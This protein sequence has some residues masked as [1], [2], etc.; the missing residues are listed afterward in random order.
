MK[1][2]II[3]EIELPQGVSAVLD[4]P[5]LTIKGPKGEN[6]RSFDYPTISLEVKDG[7]VVVSAQKATKREKR[8]IGT[9]SSHI[10]NL[11]QGVQE[12]FVYKLKICSGHF[13]MNVSVSGNSVVVKNFLGEK[14]PRVIT[15]SNGVEIKVNGTEIVVTSCSKELA[16][17]AAAKIEKGCYIA[18]RDRRIFQ[19]GIW[20]T[21][22]AGKA[23]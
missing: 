5:T 17:L 19:D 13:P 15:F 8:M 4:G 23:V 16:G 20:I 12:K 2:A 6:V 3:K 22:K 14:N 9:F 18:N 7:K 11:V 21:E 10:K 1:E